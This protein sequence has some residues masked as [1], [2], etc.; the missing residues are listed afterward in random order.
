MLAKDD[1]VPLD[2]I[3]RSN[4]VQQERTRL[5]IN[6]IAPLNKT[7]SLAPDV[8][9]KL[10]VL[11]DKEIERQDHEWMETMQMPTITERTEKRPVAIRYR[12]VERD[13]R[14]IVNQLVNSIPKY[15]LL[16]TP[17]VER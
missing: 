4:L 17:Y 3:V 2:L 13:C 12:D 14:S 15:V 5:S 7:V 16:R 6:S 8:L 10:P 1:L 9:R 11:L